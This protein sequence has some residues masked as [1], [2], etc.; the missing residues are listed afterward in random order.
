[1]RE[2]AGTA[3]FW[4]LLAGSTLVI[5][6]IG[7]VIFHFIL[8]LRDQGYSSAWAS[9]ALST[10]LLSSL[11]GR[12]VVGYLADRFTRKTV[13]ALFYLVLALVIPLLLVAH[14]PPAVWGFAILFGFAMGADYMLI[15]LVAADC[16]GLAALGRILALIIMADSLGQTSGPVMAGRLFDIRHSYD[17]A[18]MIITLAS[19]LGAGAVYL[20]APM[21]PKHRRNETYT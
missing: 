16:F 6:A 11:A 14:H 9:R 2:A 19:A 10:L 17:L 20:I 3:N 18:W 5:G 15:P 7:T 4:L 12:V 1:V 8:L 21:A 13:M